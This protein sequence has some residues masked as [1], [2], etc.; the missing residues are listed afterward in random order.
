MLHQISKNF[1]KNKTVIEDFFRK[2]FKDLIPPLYLSCDI[3][4]S[5]KKLAVIDTNLFPAGFNNLCNSYS[6]ATTLAFRDYFR[7]YYPNVRNLIILAE[8]HTRNRYYLENIYALNSLLKSTGLETRVAYP[9]IDI[10]QDTVI[11]PL[12]QDRI[13]QMSKLK[14]DQDVPIVNDF[15]GDLV[16]SNNDFTQGI[17]DYIIPIENKI[18][19]NP[20][21]GW[22]RRAKSRHFEILQGLI[23]EFS[24]LID[25]DPWLLSCI[26]SS[27]KGIDLSQKDDVET[28][29]NNTSQIFSQVQDE[30]QKNGIQD[31]PYV[32]IKNDSGTYGMGLLDVSDPEE[33]KQMN[34][35]TRNKLLSAKGG[36]EVS[37][38]LIQEGIPTTDFY[39][40]L[41]IEPVI[42]MIGFK[43]VGGFFRM[44][45]QQ[46]AQSSLNTRGM[47][48]SCLCLH[49]LDEPHEEAFLN[50]SEKESLVKM[51]YVMAKIAALASA[52]EMQELK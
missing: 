6:R 22:H 5:G 19:P 50:C 4:N 8:E 15:K 30:Y 3:R 17:P 42:Y 31:Q 36:K 16:L 34:R 47:M 9:G 14:V 45:A 41:P 11:V 35:K 38:F 27:V 44:N 46:D 52:L 28:L 7:K 13:L 25:L 20:S 24:S 1:D 48:F 18:I 12:G 33:I 49:K 10:G 51:S 26:F 40:G 29:A 39:S 23:E 32:F 21:L 37:S 2:K 43:P